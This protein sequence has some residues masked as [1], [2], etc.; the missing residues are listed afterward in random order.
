MLFELG[1]AIDRATLTVVTRLMD[2]TTSWATACDAAAT[3]DQS[4]VLLQTTTG[5]PAVDA[6][7]TLV[8]DQRWSEPTLVCPEEGN[9]P[10]TGAH[11]AG[12]LP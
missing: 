12:Q 6:P 7:R 9:I 3:R 2:E 4:Q 8:D 11:Q 10:C 1:A 5:G